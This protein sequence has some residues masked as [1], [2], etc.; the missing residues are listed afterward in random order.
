MARG[1][2]NLAVVKIA[3]D[4]LLARGV[5][6][7]I[8]AVRIELG[9]TGS[10]STILR[11]LN[12]LATHDKQQ[13]AP[14]LEEELMSLIS[15]V[16]DRLR[17][18]AQA[19]VAAERERLTRQEVEYRTQR[20]HSQERLQDLQHS[21]RELGG[22]LE[23]LRHAESTLQDQLR[24]SEIERS[25]LQ[26]VEQG[27]RRLLEERAH[28]QQSLEEKHQ[29]ARQ[30]L[31]HFRIAQKEQREQELRRQD[32]TVQQLRREIRS[33][34]ETQM[35]KQQELATLN[36]DNERLLSDARA[37]LKLQQAWECELSAL[38]RGFQEQLAAF[39]A[40]LTT[41]H[42]LLS[43]SRAENATL[44]ERL[45]QLHVKY[46]HCRRLLRAPG[47]LLLP[48]PVRPPIA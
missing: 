12:E 6:P 27:L 21:Q 48:S 19:A 8:D 46:R 4:A 39:K 41:L 9:N 2:V 17:E 13:P 35:N 7:S 22:Q 1:G 16:A 37:H 15:S 45:R 33:L 30:A 24:V 40:E 26:E 14:P 36:R 20:L 10:R 31:E 3:R 29:H 18:Q 47:K 32:E 43:T 23:Q 5:R 44:R 25:R 11:C 38:R 42:N 34:Q 28:Q